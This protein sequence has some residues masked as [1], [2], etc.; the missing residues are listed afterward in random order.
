MLLCPSGRPLS[1][2]KRKPVDRS[3]ANVVRNAARA[4]G[5]ST[6]RM[7]FS[8][9]GFCS[10][11]FQTLLRTW[12]VLQSD[13]M[14]VWSSE[15]GS[16][17]VASASPMRRPVPASKA[18]SA[19]YRPADPAITSVTCL[20][21]SVGVCCF[22]WID[23]GQGRCYSWF[24]CRGNICFPSPLIADAT[25]FFRAPKISTIVLGARCDSLSLATRSFA[26]L[27]STEGERQV[28]DQG[29]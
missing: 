12:I 20:E 5:I 21:F 13:E 7:A 8:V 19:W 2:R 6:E 15:Y 26:I 17:F 4:S 14:V 22:F 24:H 1:V 23:H 29:K 11:Q 27:L 16:S 28:P 10:R 25:T 3:A 9:L 18:Y